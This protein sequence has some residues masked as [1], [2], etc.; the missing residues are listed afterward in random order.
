LN[1]LDLAHTVVD[2]IEEKMGESILLLDLKG[3]SIV[4]DYFVIA[5]GRSDRQLKALARVVA[6]LAGQKRSARLRDLGAQAASGWVLLDLGEVIVHLFM[7][8]QRDYYGLEKL[9]SH[10]KVLLRVQ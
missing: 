6:E 3:I 5:T 7:R 8:G 10:G 4:A 1:S 2:A 9:W